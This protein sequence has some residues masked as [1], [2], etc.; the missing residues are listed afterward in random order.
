MANKTDHP[1][2][3]KE[4]HNKSIDKFNEYINSKTTLKKGD[5]KKLQLQRDKWQDAWNEMMETLL[6]LERIEI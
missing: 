3:L 4:L 5:H 2:E 1:K 6:V